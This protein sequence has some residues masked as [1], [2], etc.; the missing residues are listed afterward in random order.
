MRKDRS[1]PGFLLGPL[2]SISV[3]DGVQYGLTWMKFYQAY[4]KSKETQ[5]IQ[6]LGV[7]L[8]STPTSMD[9]ALTNQ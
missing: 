5:H 9:K 4:K 6:Y 3:S 1:I 7:E 2:P 8:L